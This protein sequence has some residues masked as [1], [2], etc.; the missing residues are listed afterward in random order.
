MA[1]HGFCDPRWMASR[2][3][4]RLLEDIPHSLTSV[5]AAVL[6]VVDIPALKDVWNRRASR[7]CHMQHPM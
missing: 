4:G 2:V 7:R 6:I 5:R 1:K 3:A